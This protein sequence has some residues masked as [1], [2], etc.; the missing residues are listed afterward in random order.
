M[1]WF[2]GTTEEL[3]SIATRRAQAAFPLRGLVCQSKFLY[4]KAYIARVN[5]TQGML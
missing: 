5:R 2:T 3:Y 1:S 4:L